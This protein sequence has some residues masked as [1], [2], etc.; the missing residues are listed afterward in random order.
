M[1]EEKLTQNSMK[2]VLIQAT[3]YFTYLYTLIPPL[4][5]KLMKKSAKCTKTVSEGAKI[6]KEMNEELLTT[7]DN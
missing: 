4:F 7:L 5:H 2:W 6:A 1:T 3:S